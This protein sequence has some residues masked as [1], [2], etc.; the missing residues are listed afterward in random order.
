MPEQARDGSPMPP[1]LEARGS[2][3]SGAELAAR[4]QRGE[5]RRRLTDRPLRR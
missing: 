4:Q 5:R 2:A 1:E 3:A